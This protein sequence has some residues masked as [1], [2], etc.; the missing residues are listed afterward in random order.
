VKNHYRSLNVIVKLE[1]DSLKKEDLFWIWN[2]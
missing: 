2:M 1:Y